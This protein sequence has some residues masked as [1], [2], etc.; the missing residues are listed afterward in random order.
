MSEKTIM[1]GAEI[2]AALEKMAAEI[3]AGAGD[4]SSFAIVGIQTR[5]VHLAARLKALLEKDKGASLE[6]GKLDITFYR[7]DL[8]CRGRLPEI[9]ETDITFDIEGKT[10][11]LV[12]D[13]LFTGRTIKAAM[14]NLTSF[15]RPRRI[16][17]AVL[18]DRGN[19]EMPVQ[20][21]F[22]GLRI[23]TAASDK[24]SVKLHELDG[25]DGVELF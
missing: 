18:V 15:G 9:K 16:M 8:S 21:D 13:V 20:P 3:A 12:D 5:G 22:C 10:L 14:E 2:N 1:S 23:V 19:R 24:V 7:D 25:Y 11:L 6:S 17:L 4:F